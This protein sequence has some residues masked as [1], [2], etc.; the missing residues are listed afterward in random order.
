MQT[1]AKRSRREIDEGGR[2]SGS[3]EREKES[4]ERESGRCIHNGPQTQNDAPL[5][6]PSTCY[7]PSLRSWSR[8]EDGSPHFLAGCDE[9]VKVRAGSRCAELRLQPTAFLPDSVPWGKDML[10]RKEKKREK[11]FV[12]ARLLV[13]RGGGTK[14][15]D[16]ERRERRVAAHIHRRARGGRGVTGKKWETG[17]TQAGESHAHTQKDRGIP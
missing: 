14:L 8:G 9:R 10:R 4:K 12:C 13:E 15:K 2:G 1:R 17:I 3:D 5:A 7:R 6:T 16:R 11:R